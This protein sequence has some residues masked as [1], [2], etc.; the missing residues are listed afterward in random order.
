MNE[1]DF[2][3]FTALSE[4]ELC[5]IEGGSYGKKIHDERI[6]LELTQKQLADR[7][8]V[9]DKAVANWE[10]ERTEPDMHCLQM[11][12]KVF[13]ITIEELIDDEPSKI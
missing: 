11:L 8:F 5:E 1:F 12:S 2:D 6:K 9:S 10:H 13:S 7:L 4:E 3:K